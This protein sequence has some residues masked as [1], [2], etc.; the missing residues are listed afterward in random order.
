MNPDRPYL[1][2]NAT[3]GTVG[4]PPVGDKPMCSESS[5]TNVPFGCIFTF[6]VEDFARM[7][8]D[9]A[10]YEIARAVMASATFPAVFN[11]TTLKDYAKSNP[12][13]RYLH[14]FDGGNADNLGLESVRRVIE[15]NLG[16]HDRI[17]VILVDADVSS[18][19]IPSTGANP[20]EPVDYVV[21]MN[22]MDSFDSLLKH[23]R[24]SSIDALKAY[25]DRAAEVGGDS[26]T[27]F[28]YHLKFDNVCGRR[29]SGQEPCRNHTL[30][31]RLNAIK[32]DFR[33]D[34][35]GVSAIDEALAL[36]M[37]SENGCLELIRD[38]LTEDRVE[39]VKG[40]RSYPYCT[41][42]QGEPL[43]RKS[44]S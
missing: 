10:G 40:I 28:L 41:W 1:I 20:R 25:M 2:I 39:H 30:L 5:E 9:L 36:L 7:H 37:V 33:I 14:L 8:S 32:T 4:E 35:E 6:T 24:Y 29:L 43:E 11:Y 17:V 22:V 23:A 34:D 44:S 38:I 42:N 26:K 19:R 21:D 31:N 13:D 12:T 27:M 18:G 15:G 3:N 16:N